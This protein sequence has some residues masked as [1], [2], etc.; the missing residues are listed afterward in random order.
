MPFGI[1]DYGLIQGGVFQ[2]VGHLNDVRGDGFN[3]EIRTAKGNPVSIDFL[4]EGITSVKTVAGAALPELPAAN[5]EAKLTYE[6]QKKNS[7]V[8]KAAE[9]NV[10]RMENIREVA[11]RLAQMRRDKKWSRRY[12]VVS[13][14]YTGSTV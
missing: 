13:T 7:F 8:V 5:V 11:D 4:S 2:K 6:F 1:G 12:C 14:T 10:E 3:V 9:M